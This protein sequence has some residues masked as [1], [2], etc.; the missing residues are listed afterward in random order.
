MSRGVR[1]G[2]PIS[3]LLFI[4]STEIMNEKV[5]KCPD[6]KGIEVND[7]VSKLFA[8]ADDTTL[9]P[10]DESSVTAALHIIDQFG[11]YSGLT[12]N[13]DKCKGIW[14]GCKRDL[15]ETY[16]N[17]SFTNEPVKCMG[18][19]FGHSKELLYSLN[20]ERKLLQIDKLLNSWTHRKLT[21]F[22]KVQVIK[23]LALS[24]LSYT[25]SI[26]PLEKKAIKKA[27]SMIY[28]F[29]WGKKERIKRRTLI[30]KYEDGGISMPDVES[31]AYAAKAKWI[32]RIYSIDSWKQRNLSYHVLN[33]YLTQ[34]GLCAKTLLKCNF[35]MEK[36]TEQLTLPVFYKE[37][38][39]AYNKCKF[40]KCVDKMNNYDFQSQIIWCNSLFKFNNKCLLFKNWIKGGI[41]FVRDL[42]NQNG[43]FL[44]STDVLSRL[45]S[46]H[47]WISEYRTIVK[48]MKPYIDKN[49][50]DFTYCK[51]INVSIN[52][53][54]M[55]SD[56]KKLIDLNEK[57]GRQQHFF[58]QILVSKKFCRP[59]IEKT[60]KK[61]FIICIDSVTWKEI[62][63]R[64]C[65]S[66]SDKKLCEFRFK[67]LHNLLICNS[68]LYKWKCT[69]SYSCNYCN[70][71]ETTRHQIYDCA[72][73]H[74]FWQKVGE[75]LNVSIKWKHL[76]LGFDD[77]NMIGRTRNLIC[78]II[79]YTMYLHCYKVKEG[80]TQ[81]LKDYLVGYLIFY[82]KVIASTDGPYN[83]NK[84]MYNKILICLSS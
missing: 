33:S 20:W 52:D 16:E 76:V 8:Y 44:S 69:T 55:L 50:F 39:F 58:Y 17:I 40:T 62:Y 80:N 60:W 71:V 38:F 1:Q 6:I 13:R 21:L 51:H 72:E 61:E 68:K 23:S 34:T 32:C 19:Y 63:I 65:S 48:V 5:R 49:I 56:G 18:V 25:F 77:S 82:S 2:C 47:N 7:N 46:K 10:I 12:L 37:V 35:T 31:T 43:H 24:Q 81:P 42:F 29:L 59:Y 45:K 64:A 15:C 26:L 67:L 74:C 22:G 66:M 84:E 3:A 30:G 54:V 27:E 78:S 75:T 28:D 57:R 9:T 4:L 83:I 79:M 70:E 36:E 41:V 11:K 53:K 14:L 73:K